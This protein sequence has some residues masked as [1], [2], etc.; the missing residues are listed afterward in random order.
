MRQRS[1]HS[2]PLR[3]YDAAEL[4]DALDLLCM[5]GS[6]RSRDK[7]PD[8]GKPFAGKP[9]RCPEE[10]CKTRPEGPFHV[11]IYHGGQLH[12]LYSGKQGETL[13]SQKQALALLAQINTEIK[14]K[15]W[16]PGAYN[17]NRGRSPA[18]WLWRAYA[19]KVIDDKAAGVEAEQSAPSTIRLQRMY[20]DRHLNPRIGDM[21]L[22]DITTGTLKELR[23]ALLEEPAHQGGGKPLSPKYAW[24]ILQFAH[25]ILAEAHRDGMIDK[26]PAVPAIKRREAPAASTLSHD[27][28]LRVLRDIQAEEPEHAPIFWAL[29]FTGHR[30]AEVAALRIRDF[31]RAKRQLHFTRTYSDGQIKQ[32][33]KAGDQHLIPIPDELCAI[34]DAMLAVRYAGGVV[35]HPDELLFVPP[36]PKRG[37]PALGHYRNH[38]LPRIWKRACERTGVPYIGLY[39]STKHSLATRMLEMGLSRSAIASM[40]GITER[41]TH[42]YAEYQAEALRPI[43]EQI[44]GAGGAQ[45]DSIGS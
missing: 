1:V 8:H 28:Q 17:K 41:S 7:C 27:E 44:H 26:I 33:R 42:H 21:D 30:P 36:R 29:Y 14:G 3:A 40:L 45:A 10:K 24:N 39:E 18:H 22:R 32:G 38:G 23:K 35:P 37:P 31:L 15:R 11:E 12:K 20:L 19:G 4:G 13:D 34:L 16:D 5:K 9:L 6:I 43:V 25:S 2:R